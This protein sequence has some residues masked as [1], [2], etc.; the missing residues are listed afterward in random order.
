MGG[1]LAVCCPCGKTIAEDV[2]VRPAETSVVYACRDRHGTVHKV[3][4]RRHW[5]LDRDFP[6][7][8]PPLAA[9][10]LLEAGD[11]EGCPYQIVAMR[12]LLRDVFAAVIKNSS[13]TLRAGAQANARS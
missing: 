2:Y 3:P 8:G 5:R 13:G 6:Q 4:A 9:R 12:D 7:F 1:Y 10:G 11:I